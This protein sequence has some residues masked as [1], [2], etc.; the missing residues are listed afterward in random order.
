MVRVLYD[1]GLYSQTVFNQQ[2]AKNRRRLDFYCRTVLYQSSHYFSEIH[3]LTRFAH[4]P[5][6]RVT[7]KLDG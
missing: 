5:P 3:E 6:S 7:N 2:S 4:E 1:S